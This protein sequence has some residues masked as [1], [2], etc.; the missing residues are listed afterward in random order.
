MD[1]LDRP[2]AP[3]HRLRFALPDRPHRGHVIPPAAGRI[4]WRALVGQVEAASPYIIEARL[5]DEA[6]IPMIV[7][8]VAVL[9][10]V[11]LN[12]HQVVPAAA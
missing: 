9:A 10:S 2:R 1:P 7:P 4:L 8:E 12:V 6:D 11:V 3:A 5:S